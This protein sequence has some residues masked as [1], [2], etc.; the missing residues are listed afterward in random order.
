M[1]PRRPRRDRCASAENPR[2]CRHRKSRAVLGFHRSCGEA[3][4]CPLPIFQI[5]AFDNLI[6]AHMSY[7]SPLLAYLVDLRLIDEQMAKHR[8]TEAE[9]RNPFGRA[10]IGED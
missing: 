4:T 5:H 2:I 7:N 3:L 8:R 9:T 10:A 1:P 6:Y